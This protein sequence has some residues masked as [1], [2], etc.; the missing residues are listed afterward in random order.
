MLLFSVQVSMYVCI[1]APLFS[2]FFKVFRCGFFF[3]CL[4]SSVSVF[5]GSF[6]DKE[7][8]EQRVAIIN[9]RPP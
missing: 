3:Q 2:R 8:C 7:N 5:Q 9:G 4:C 6:A 1:C